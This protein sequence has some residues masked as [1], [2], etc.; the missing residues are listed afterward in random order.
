[1]STVI[2]NTLTGTSTAGSISVTGEGNSTTTN[3]QQG[4]AKAWCNYNDHTGPATRDSFNVASISDEAAGKF[5]PTW[6]NNFGNA[7][8][9]TTANH[10]E[11][12]E[13]YGNYGAGSMISWSNVNRSTSV[14]YGS[15]TVDASGGF[16]DMRTIEAMFMGDLA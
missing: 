14:C 3:L 11:D 5:K 8:Y 13:A 16:T 9:A 12:G 4:L 1:M 6:T 7:N 15:T 10:A 2:V